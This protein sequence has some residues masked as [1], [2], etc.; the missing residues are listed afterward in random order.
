MLYQNMFGFCGTADMNGESFV[1][2]WKTLSRIWM[3]PCTYF[4]LLAGGAAVAAAAELSSLVL[5]RQWLVV[6]VVVSRS[7][8]DMTDYV[9]KKFLDKP[10]HSS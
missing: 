1:H 7:S 5:L 8:S 2:F 9:W 10:L 6:V 3:N 4:F